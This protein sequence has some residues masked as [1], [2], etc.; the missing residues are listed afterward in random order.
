MTSGA[1]ARFY[2]TFEKM[3]RDLDIQDDVHGTDGPI[4]ILRRQQ[5]PW[6]AI[7]TALYQAALSLGFPADPDMNGPE[8]GGVGAI[9]MNNPHGIRLS[10]ALTTSSRRATGST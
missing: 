1:I 3:E 6:P 2:R 4:P 10:T 5:E 8:A 9:P 7:Q